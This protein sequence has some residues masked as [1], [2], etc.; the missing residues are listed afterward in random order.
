MA[1]GIDP[2]VDYAFKLLFGSEENKSRTLSLIN[3][4][5]VGQ[6]PATDISFSNTVQKKLSVDGKFFI[7]DV[8]AFD[9][10]PSTAAPGFPAP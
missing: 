9:Q 7:L 6:S 5:L 3:T 2:L 4:V 10:S 1:I 8:L